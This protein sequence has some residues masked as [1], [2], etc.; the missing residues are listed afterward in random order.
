VTAVHPRLSPGLCSKM[1]SDTLAVIPGTGDAR[2]TLGNELS[3]GPSRSAVEAA[4]NPLCSRLFCPLVR[5]LAAIRAVGGCAIGGGLGRMIRSLPYR[6]H[7]RR[8]ST[9]PL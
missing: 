2:H 6:S 1:E 7:P 4:N 9:G 3:V 8:G 5:P